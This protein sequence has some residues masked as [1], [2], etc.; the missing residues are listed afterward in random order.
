MIAEDGTDI[1]PGSGERGLLAIGGRQPLGYYKDEAKTAAS[2]RIID[3][4]R[5]V[6]AGDWATHRCATAW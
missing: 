4:K 3:G 1:V 2:F 6:V 5:Y